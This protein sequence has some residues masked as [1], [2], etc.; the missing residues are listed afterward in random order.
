MD[1]Q[2]KNN[3]TAEWL[4]DLNSKQSAIYSSA[5]STNERRA[6]RKIHKTEFAAFKCMDGRLNL[7]VYTNTPTGIIKPFRT[8]GGVFDLG[9]E[10]LGRI[11]EEDIQRCIDN[12]KTYIPFTS[13]HFSKGSGHRGCAGHNYNTENAVRSAKRLLKQFLATYCSTSVEG[14]Y[15]TKIVFPIMIGFETDFESLLLHSSDDKVFSVQDYLDKNESEWKKDLHEFFPKME[16]KM[17]EGLSALISGNIAHIKEIIAEKRPIIGL[18]HKESVICYGRGFDWLHTPNKALI[19]GPYGRDQESSIIKA[20]GVLLDSIEKGRINPEDGLVIMTAGLFHDTGM[21]KNRVSQK[22]YYLHRYIKKVIE[23]N[24]PDLAKKYDLQ[25]LVGVTSHDTRE[26]TEI[27][28]QAFEKNLDN[29]FGLSEKEIS[30]ITVE[31][32]EAVN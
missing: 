31:E 24:V 11:V 21:N 12:G 7:S 26:F 4:L 15:N 8:M 2:R 25:Y 27:D 32:M 23:E 22:S 10:N 9:D 29:E 19:I 28:V 6:Y 16:E 30:A 1:T 13:Y 3:K 17:F 20:G 18:Q 5:G 14:V